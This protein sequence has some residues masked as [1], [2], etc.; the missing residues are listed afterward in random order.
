MDYIH[1]CMTTLGAVT[2]ASDGAALT[3]LWFD[4]QKHFGRTLEMNSA[5]AELPVFAEV[6]RW[7]DIYFSG[8]CPEFTPELRL[9]GSNFAVSVWEALLAIPYGQTVTYG[10]IA[11]RLAARLEGARVSP[12]A[13]GAA[14]GRNPVSLIVPCHRVIGADGSLTGYAGGLERKKRL[15]RLEGAIQT[16]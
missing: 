11:R 7:L 5:E 4:G 2:L 1:R 10:E 13:V 14:V 8:T 9:K 12:R 16:G 3:G 15:L 6:E